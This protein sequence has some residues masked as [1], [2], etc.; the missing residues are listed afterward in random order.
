MAEFDS[1]GRYANESVQHLN[2][3][4]LLESG[5]LW[6]LLRF[7]CRRYGREFC[8]FVSSDDSLCKLVRQRAT[9]CLWMESDVFGDSTQVCWLE[10][11]SQHG[12]SSHTAFILSIFRCHSS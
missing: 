1:L 2:C 10:S 4:G 9:H 11:G 3:S 8:G 12:L 5:C 7:G 6:N